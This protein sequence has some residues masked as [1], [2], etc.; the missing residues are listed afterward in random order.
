M[1][2]LN[3]IQLRV[4]AGCN[5]ETRYSR[6]TNCKIT[7]E[8]L[9]FIIPPLSPCPPPSFQVDDESLEGLSYSN[10]RLLLR[11]TEG[12]VELVVLRRRKKE[13]SAPDDE[14][15]DS[16]DSSTDTEQLPPL[17]STPLPNDDN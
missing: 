8:W 2:A 11:Q 17:P 16:G 5:L 7:A 13:T 10:A 1:E 15:D 9:N 14:D 3:Q 6:Y 4:T 12:L